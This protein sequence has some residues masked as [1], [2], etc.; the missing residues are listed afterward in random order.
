MNKN[1]LAC[2]KTVRKRNNQKWLRGRAT[3][4][5]TRVVKDQG[6]KERLC[7]ALNLFRDSDEA[8]IL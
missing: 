3:L 4:V 2:G 8:N 7:Q 5:A 6:S 1:I